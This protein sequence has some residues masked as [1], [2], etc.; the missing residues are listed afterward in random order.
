MVSKLDSI[1]DFRIFDAI[2]RMGS[3]SA[4]ARD[5]ELSLTTISKRLKHVE[6]RLGLRLILRTTRQ[7]VLT[8]EGE[9]FHERVRA[10]LA[11]VA[12]AEELGREAT[13]RG[14]I[15]ITTTVAFAQR[16]L[17]P[18]IPRFL[19]ENPAVELQ[20][21]TSDRIIDLVAEKVDLA[22]RQASLDDS[23]LITRTIAEDALLLVA[24]PDYARRV[25]L[26]DHPNDLFGHRA[27]TV[28]DPPPR[29]WRLSREG[30]TIDVPIRSGVAS[31]D[32]EVAHAVALAGG[33]VAMKSSWDVIEDLRSGA[34]V[35]VLP[36]WW[37]PPRML[38]CVF[39]MREHQPM[40][41]RALVEFMERE[42]KTAMRQ[43]SDLRLL[44]TQSA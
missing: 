13:A 21:N 20:I 24:S 16:Q 40:R 41:V 12:D 15:R 19:K 22:F 37:G 30:E 25:G 10:V 33:G 23:R 6:N 27:L 38:R 39:P 36:G 26:P 32:G 18:R 3:L 1:D 35:H 5:L 43:L 4:A 9:A 11:T 29:S 14:V 28:G 8:P 17:A 42:L 7:L 44:P 34:L 31:L 2:A